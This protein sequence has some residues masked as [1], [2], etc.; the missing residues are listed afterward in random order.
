ML[1]ALIGYTGF[2]GN[3]ILSQAKFS[4]LYNSKNIKDIER[5]SYDL[6]VSAATTSLKWQANLEPEKDWE[7]I[8]K[9]IDSLKHVQAKFFILISTVDVYPNPQNV[10]EDT[11]INPE[12]LTQGYGRNRYKLEKLVVK[13]FPNTLILRL[14][15]TFGEGLKKNVVFDLI[16]DNRWDLIHKDNKFQWYNLENIWRDIQIALKNSL[17]LVNLA[18]E[19]LSVEKVAK[20]TL[21]LDF[22]NVTKNPPVNYNMLTKYGYLYGSK[23][24]YLYNKEI[25]LSALKKFIKSKRK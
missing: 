14:P 4:N 13:K 16:H 15:Q 22:T 11:L 20:Y 6:I 18:V 10:N 9:L 5:K 2:I 3:N 25:T 23:T 7:V 12:N 24:K 21:N 17:K 8:E 1:S 19:P